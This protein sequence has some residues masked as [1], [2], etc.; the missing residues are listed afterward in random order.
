MGE[1]NFDWIIGVGILLFVGF[2]NIECKVIGVDGYIDGLFQ[3]FGC[4]YQLMVGFSYNKCEYVNYGDYQVGGLGQI[5]DLF[6]SYLNWMGKIGELNWN[7]LVLV[8][9]GI[10]MQKVGYVVVC[11]LLVDLFKL[12]IGVCYIDWKSEGEGVDCVYKVIMLYVGLVFDINDIYLIYVSYIEIFQ[13]QML[14]DCNGSYFDLVDGKSY[15]VGVKG[16]WFDNCLNVLLVVFCIEQDNVGQVIGE[17]VQGS[18]NEFV[19]CVV[20]GIVSCGFEF[21]VNGELV[22]G[23]NVIFGVLCYVVKDI[24]GVDININLLQIVLKLFI[25]YILQLLQV[26]IVGGGVNWQ[27]CIYYLVLVYGC[28]EQSG[29]VLVSVFLCYCILLEFSVQVNFNNLLDKK[30]LLQINGYGVYGDGCN[31]LL[32]FIWVF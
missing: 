1:L 32:M 27:N 21:E 14:K 17:L 29:Y 22:L 9:E 19:Y 20:C 11:L 2:Y 23:W 25:S 13:L 15:E 16:V 12:I 28:I 31:G 6:V 5:W 3:L 8:S 10:I 18:Q 26:L 4:E 7:L 30:Y 24:N